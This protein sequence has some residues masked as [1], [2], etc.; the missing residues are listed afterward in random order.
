MK[1]IVILQTFISRSSFSV[2]LTSFDLQLVNIGF[3]ALG[4]WWIFMEEVRH[5]LHF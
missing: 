3:P 1:H 2:V 5:S 4:I